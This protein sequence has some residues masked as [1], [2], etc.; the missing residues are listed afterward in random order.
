M[1][2]FPPLLFAWNMVLRALGHLLGFIRSHGYKNV[3]CLGRKLS[4]LW[5]CYSDMFIW[6]CLICSKTLIRVWLSVQQSV[7]WRLN[8]I[9]GLIT[10]MDATL[11]C[12]SCF[13]AKRGFDY[14]ACAISFYLMSIYLKAKFAGARS[15]IRN[16]IISRNAQSIVPQP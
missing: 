4:N 6:L 14:N 7:M 2:V 16:E 5:F 12:N 13:F 15:S 10:N 11:L 3:C 9:F 1:H 8:T